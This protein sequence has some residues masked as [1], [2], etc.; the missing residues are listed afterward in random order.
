MPNWRELSRVVPSRAERKA[1][2]RWIERSL[3]MAGMLLLLPLPQ[4]AAAES[5][6][7]IVE[8]VTLP[9]DQGQLS[10]NFPGI[11]RDVL[12]KEGDTVAAGQPLMV[13]DDEIEQR[14]LEKLQLEASSTAR[15]DAAKADLAVKEKVYQRKKAAEGGFTQAEIEEAELDVIFR[16]NQVKV[17]EIDRQSNQIE[18]KKQAARVERMTLR[19]P[20]DGIVQKIGLRRGEFAELQKDKPAVVVVKNDPCWVEIRLL[21]SWQASRL[22]MGQTLEVRYPDEP[23]WRLARV[24][25]IDPVANAASNTQLV[26]LELPNPQ[27]K[28]TGLPIQVKLPDELIDRQMDSAAFR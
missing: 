17:V 12:V 11:V 24:I 18:A 22:R 2:M 20:I 7:A 21:K 27:N 26:R 16:Q 15:L 13:L 8:A 6:A 28:A 9:S 10:F 3:L 1:T 19:S 4:A 14:E 25:F 23:Q 5:P